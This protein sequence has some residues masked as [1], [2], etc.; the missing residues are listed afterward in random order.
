M[1]SADPS[2]P[3]AGRPVGS[4]RRPLAP[5]P[6]LAAWRRA[7]RLSERTPRFTPGSIALLGYRLRFQDLLTFCPQ[8]HDIFVRQTYRFAATS[9]A[10]RILD[11]GANVGLASLYF[12][13]LYPL[14]QV[15]A[16]EAD[17]DLHA[18]LV[19]NLSANLRGEASEGVEAV[20]AAV[21]T[22]NGS[23]AF[24]CEGG[25]S[26]RIEELASREAPGAESRGPA[27][28][29]P[30]VRLRDILLREG[31]GRIELL[32]LDIEGAEVD[33]LADCAPALDAVRALIVEIHEFDPVRRRSAELLQL[34]SERGFH[35]TV[36]D[37]IALPWDRP[38]APPGSPFAGR[39]LCWVVMVRAWRV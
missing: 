7:C 14:A 36:D 21:W 31:G 18:L 34:L 32:K 16:F 25:D 11:C 19:A 26:G 1:S 12:K 37:L 27:R 2:P 8:W 29:V 4:R 35:Y 15:T 23:L 38:A 3:R 20:H 13:R 9:S 39:P 28:Q 6:E 5:G 30:A 33:V 17:P 24:R 22:R 10:P